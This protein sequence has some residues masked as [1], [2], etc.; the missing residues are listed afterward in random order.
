LPD[1]TPNAC[2]ASQYQL[3]PAQQQLIHTDGQAILLDVCVYQ[4][5]FGSGK[6]W[7]GSLLGILLAQQYPGIVGMAVAKTYPLLRDTTLQCYFEHFEA[8]GMQQGKDYIWRASEHKLIF[9]KWGRS[10]IL[11]RHLASPEK[12]KSLSLGWIHVEEM[13]QI[14]EADFL[15]LLSRLR[16]SNVPRYRLFGTTNPQ[17]NKGWIF[18]YFTAPK[19][20]NNPTIQYRRVL[21]PTT[22][23]TYLSAA[24]VDNMKQQFDPDYYR[25]NVLGQDGDYTAGLVCK[26]FSDSN[27]EDTPYHPDL[28]LY[29][30]CDFNVDPMCWVL[31][32]RYN[33]EYHY[34]DELCL[35]N[36]TTVQAAEEFYN[37]YRDHQASIIITGDASGQNRSSHADHAL[38][39]NYTLLRNQLSRFGFRQVDIDVRPRNPSILSRVESW[40][41]MVCNGEGHRRVK[42]NPKCKW[43]IENCN[44]LKYIAGTSMIWE[45]TS[46]QIETDNKLKFVKHIWD[47]ASYLIERYNPITLEIPKEQRYKSRIVAKGFRPNRR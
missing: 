16:Q 11:F 9:P 44:N 18:K 4:G 32:H 26:T 38:S 15:M 28:K 45:P 30:S 41:A 40:N 19:E 29:L 5:G 22:Q 36:T 23:N 14:M 35:E 39:T 25:M 33:N 37:R 27:I 43:L 8:M 42:I 12:I 47:A 46:R 17:P 21:A 7:A 6:T 13:S 20:N 1:W 10:Q 3:L 34:I 24:Y 2:N 31:A